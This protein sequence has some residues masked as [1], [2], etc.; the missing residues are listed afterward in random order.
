M[1]EHSQLPSCPL[2]GLATALGGVETEM[3]HTGCSPLLPRILTSEVTCGLTVGTEGPECIF[4]QNDRI[5]WGSGA[6][7]IPGAEGQ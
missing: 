7:L 5:S 2:W 4:W 3:T 1:E 6:G